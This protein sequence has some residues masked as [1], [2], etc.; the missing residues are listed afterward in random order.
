M[1]ELLTAFTSGLLAFLSPC[2]LPLLP[3]LITST[4]TQQGAKVWLLPIG[5][6]LSFSAFGTL[7]YFISQLIS[8][9]LLQAISVYLI[10]IFGALLLWQSLHKLQILKATDSIASFKANY[11]SLL[12]QKISQYLDKIQ[13]KTLYPLYLGL[14]LGLS[15]APCITYTLGVALSLAANGTDLVRA[16]GIMFMFSLGVCVPIIALV[17]QFKYFSNKKFKINKLQQRSI[18][19]AQLVFALSLVLWSFLSLTGLD[20]RLASLINLL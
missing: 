16:S 8:V 4:I 17:L 13:H 1:L 20:K 11:W 9:N 12:T 2:V 3:I 6:A 5:L 18:A 19:W 7:T 14:F 15:W 10:L